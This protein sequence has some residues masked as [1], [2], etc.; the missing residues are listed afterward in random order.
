MSTILCQCA[1]CRRV[2]AIDR[3]RDH[4]ICP[5]CRAHSDQRQ[6]ICLPVEVI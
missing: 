3:V 5:E 2:Y 1:R 6:I 4:M